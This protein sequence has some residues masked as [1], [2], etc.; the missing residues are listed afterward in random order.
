MSIIHLA[1]DIDVVHCDMASESGR[2]HRLSDSVSLPVLRTS[3]LPQERQ[4]WEVL[5]DGVARVGGDEGFH[6]QRS[7]PQVR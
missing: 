6:L 7:H 4:R 2:P 1:R 5:E 3:G